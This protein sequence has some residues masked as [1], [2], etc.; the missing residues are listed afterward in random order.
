MKDFRFMLVPSARVLDK[1]NL[2]ET[3][4]FCLR[5]NILYMAKKFI[6][7][8]NKSKK[9]T[10]PYETVNFCT[11]EVIFRDLC[12]AEMNFLAMDKIFCRRQKFFVPDKFDFV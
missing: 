3:N 4:F 10:L 8:T 9:I 12:K 1:S 7:A 5:Q 2:S 6:S 11:K